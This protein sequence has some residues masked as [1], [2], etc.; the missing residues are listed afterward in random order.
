MV[1]GFKGYV[2]STVAR[3]AAGIPEGMHFCM[4][5]A[6]HLVIALAY[7]LTIFHYYRSDTRI[8]RGSAK[9]FFCLLQG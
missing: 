1:T 9:T 7:H 6:G 2:E 5:S 3:I 4:R 8:R